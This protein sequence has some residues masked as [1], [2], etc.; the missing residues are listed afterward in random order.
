MKPTRIKSTM[1][2]HSPYY[3]CATRI[4]DTSSG[5][6]ALGQWAE[7]FSASCGV[8]ETGWPR[9][10]AEE[11]GY[12]IRMNQPASRGSWLPNLTS[13]EIDAMDLTKTG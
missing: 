3:R 7:C 1:T 4:T 2:H 13:A 6:A 12:H 11:T 5:Y 10:D 8:P 9:D